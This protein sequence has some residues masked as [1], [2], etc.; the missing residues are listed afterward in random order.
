MPTPT[1]RPIELMNPMPLARHFVSYSSG[2]HSVY[3]AKL[4]PAT[5]SRNV[6]TKNVLSA[7]I[8]R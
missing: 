1:K 8:C 3:I 2:S 6:N 5:P 7:F 4:A